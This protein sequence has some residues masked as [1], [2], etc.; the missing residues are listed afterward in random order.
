M[1]FFHPYILYAL[2]FLTV[3]FLLLF[4]VNRKKIV[5]HWA[6]YQ[7]MQKAVISRKKNIRITDLLKL[8]SKLF[9]ITAI[10]LAATR[11]ATR[12]GKGGTTMLIVDNTL[13]MAVALDNGTR[14][15]RA[16]QLASEFLSSTDN[17]TVAFT[18]DGKLTPLTHI[19][20]NGDRSGFAGSVELT[21][22]TASARQ[23]VDAVTSAPI[24]NKID[25]VLFISDFQK[26]HYRDTNLHQ[27][28]LER[29]GKDKSIIFVPVDTRTGLANVSIESF[30][31]LPEGFFPGRANGI[32]VKLKNRGDVPIESLPVTVHIDGK[33]VDRSLISFVG[34]EEAEALLNLG[35]ADSAPHNA[36]ITVPQDTFSLD[37]VFNFV[38]TPGFSLNV[39]A[40]TGER[41]KENQFK[42]DQFFASAL[43]SFISDDYLNYKSINPHEIYAQN[44][45]K[46]DLIVTFGIPFSANDS[47]TTLL[48]DSIR[49]GTGL[50]TFNDLSVPGFWRGLGIEHSDI[51]KELSQ[52]DVSRL[53][54]GYLGFMTR[55]G[56]NPSL[57]NFNRFVTVS[58]TPNNIISRLHI[59]DNLDPIIASKNIGK[60]T[61]V[62]AGFMP[63]P[64]YTDFFYNPNF[65]QFCTRMVSDALSI[66]FTSA[67]IGDEVQNIPFAAFNPRGT[68]R[69]TSDSG[70]SQEVELKNQK[71]GFCLSVKPVA[72]N[73]FCTIEQGNKTVV[74]YGS[75]VTRE[76]SDIEPAEV[77]LFSEA[78]EKGL[79]YDVDQSMSV[80][81]TRHELFW[82]TMI[83]LILAL[84][85]EFY[86]HFLRGA[87]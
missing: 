60:G 78:I 8:L 77:S 42:L 29:L 11:P 24:L 67:Y 53:G 84:M 7:W 86:A 4:F 35:P 87:K 45:E 23:F 74:S 33:K 71:T 20:G 64:G 66:S 85:F 50:I 70:L 75:N 46:Y 69:M 28:L 65:V 34:H 19:G 32:R 48:L 59:T 79:V 73:S 39:L 81:G 26:Q 63:Y 52:P 16:N 54:R 40:I 51:I 83:L 56:L 1:T 76:D 27:E 62:F 55:G 10:V 21:H 61:V 12:M 37:N 82:L 2:V 14:L 22:K 17:N 18:F 47:F 49:N 15:D 72:E 36:S 41:K 31:L 3:P 80:K 57:I 13:S 25:T 5:I 9:L 58:S 68:F 44:L 38:I 30:S 43:R 6:A